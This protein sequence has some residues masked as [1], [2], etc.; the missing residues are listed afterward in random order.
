MCPLVLRGTNGWAAHSWIAGPMASPS[1]PFPA[2]VLPPHPFP[3]PSPVLF[4][5]TPLLLP[6]LAVARAAGTHCPPSLR[7]LP[8]PSLCSGFSWLGSRRQR[9]GARVCGEGRRGPAWNSLSGLDRVPIS[10]VGDP[11][12][13]AGGGGGGPPPPP[14]PRPA[15]VVLGLDGMTSP[16]SRGLHVRTP[17]ASS[18][19]LTKRDQ[20]AL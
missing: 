7:P 1:P 3:I 8:I 5:S 18:L 14:T 20:R 2:P 17:D 4:S 16:R 15:L 19:H 12:P 9:A 10:S 13:R 6:S 11:G